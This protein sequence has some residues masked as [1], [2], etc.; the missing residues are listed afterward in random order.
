MADFK[1]FNG[2]NVKDE[3]ARRDILES[4]GNR[5]FDHI[6]SFNGHIKNVLVDKAYINHE[7][8][9]NATNTSVETLVLLKNNLTYK[10]DDPTANE[11]I[12]FPSNIYSELEIKGYTANES[13]AT[14]QG[15]PN[16]FSAVK[17]NASGMIGTCA[18]AGRTYL[19]N[20]TDNPDIIERGAA[21]G[22][23][24]DAQMFTDTE[25]E[26]GGYALGMEIDMFDTCNKGV[27]P[28]YEND[29]YGAWKRT[30]C[31][32]IIGCGGN[33]QPISQGIRIQGMPSFQNGCWNGIVIG[34]SA[35]KINGVGGVKGLVGINMGSWR[36]DRGYGEIG[37]KH[38]HASRHVYCKNAYKIASDKT[39]IYPLETG[40]DNLQF[41]LCNET[42]KGTSL[43]FN[44]VDDITAEN[45]QRTELGGLMHGSDVMMTLF[46]N[47]RAIRLSIR[48]N[49]EEVGG[50]SITSG[51]IVPFTNGTTN[52]GNSE[53]PFNFVCCK[54]IKIGN[55]TL[56][57]AQL[58]T[59]LGI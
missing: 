5:R 35:M 38:G 46:G 28:V 1:S 51:Q 43:I 39:A 31:G 59:L 21:K 30:T 18:F 3:V 4:I 12:K 16:I 42:G 44:S 52:L 13:E 25:Y 22:G 55:T 17:N 8:E 26:H 23:V 27:S 34:Q 14:G 37:I 54:T 29:D 49:N 19:P 36:S 10:D 20:S 45:P 50:L 2:F 11:N 53:H 9:T 15:F 57:E 7:T 32:L 58:K 6:K 48:S 40:T 56:N 33:T 24:Y 41:L 47:N